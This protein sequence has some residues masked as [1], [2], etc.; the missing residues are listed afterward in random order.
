MSSGRRF[1]ECGEECSGK[2]DSKV[3]GESCVLREMEGKGVGGGGAKTVSNTLVSAVCGEATEAAAV[4]KVVEP[5][6]V[7]RGNDGGTAVGDHEPF[8]I[9]PPFDVPGAYP[10]GGV[11]PD[12]TQQW[13]QPQTFATG[14]GYQF[15]Q[16]MASHGSANQL[17][18]PAPNSSPGV[19]NYSGG[20]AAR[21]SNSSTSPIVNEPMVP[22]IN[23]SSHPD[24]D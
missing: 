12:Y 7:D 24:N 3:S 15:P 4:P 5:L 11:P 22:N 8:P 20:D 1:E 18:S 9:Y 10:S 13:T 17:K 6:E 16:N 2:G 19:W 23:Y 14:Q 21:Q